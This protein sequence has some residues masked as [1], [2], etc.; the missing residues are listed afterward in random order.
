MVEVG[1]MRVMDIL[2]HA[3]NRIA[4]GEVL[5]L[6]NA[7]D[8]D[9]DQQ[10]YMEVIERKTATLFEAGTRLG[11]V[12]AGSPAQVEESLARYGRL[13]GI[14]FQLIDDALDYEGDPCE[15]GKNLGDD[16]EEGKPTLPVIRAMEVGTEAQ[17]CLLRD[18]IEHGGR[19]RIDEVAAA[20]ASTDGIAYTAALSRDYA[21]RAKA[22]LAV[23]G[24]S[25]AAQAL[26]ALADFA[27][28]R[29]S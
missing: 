7:K 17:R 26:A 5:Q 6:L 1:N 12:L 11:A 18:A 21:A 29:R 19:E 28:A 22:E 23:L 10:R 16:L 15:L 25:A 2:S 9:T 3:T 20:I 27:V 13:L 14:A 8:P 24:G 4:E